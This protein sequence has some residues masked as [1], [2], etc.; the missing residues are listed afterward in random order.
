MSYVGGGV[1]MRGSRPRVCGNQ[2][3]YTGC[4]GGW[5]KGIGGVVG[6]GRMDVLVW[7]NAGGGKVAR[8]KGR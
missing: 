4:I 7:R 8:G 6:V 1:K 3:G 5:C 2:I